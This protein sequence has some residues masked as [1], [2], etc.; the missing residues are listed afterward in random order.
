MSE[1]QVYHFMAKIKLINAGMLVEANEIDGLITSQDGNIE[2]VKMQVGAW[3]KH[4]PTKRQQ[5]TL[6]NDAYR[7][8]EKLFLKQQCQ[9][10]CQN[11]KAY[12]P[13]FRNDGMVKIFQKPLSAKNAQLNVGMNMVM[14]NKCSEIYVS[15]VKVMNILKKLWC[16]ESEIMNLLYGD[17]PQM[18]FFQVIAVSPSKFR[19]ISKMGDMM[20][21]HAQNTYLVEIL[22]NNI[23]IRDIK[24]QEQSWLNSNLKV[25]DSEK[26][27]MNSQFS[28]KMIDT[29]V[30]L[31]ES[32]NNLIDSS[33][34]P[35]APGKIAPPGIRQILEKK[36]GLFRKHMMGKRVNYAARSVISPDPY[37]ETNEIGIPPVFAKKL[38]Y[39][40]PVTHHNFHQLRQCVVNGPDQWPGATHVQNEDGTL[41]ALGAFDQAG[42]QA[43]AN[44]LLTP[45]PN[46]SKCKFM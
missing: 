21:E 2:A 19:P 22:K 43:I 11:C 39:P 35:S 44:Q 20:F 13:Q 4:A 15:P 42:R 3:L 7:K 34:A 27:E 12:N 25:Q 24:Q 29:W 40:E 37:I 30:K 45:S 8:L 16:N 14:D 17:S 1:Q 26:L 5:T 23:M 32:I 28:K 36:E 41:V 6:V 38:T 31:Q 18:F 46:A 10:K 33:K 9:G